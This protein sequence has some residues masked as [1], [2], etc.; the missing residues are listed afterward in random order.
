M[1]DEEAFRETAL[2]RLTSIDHGMAEVNRHLRILNGRV[3]KLE[4]RNAERDIK[5]AREDGYED[6][7]SLAVVTKAQL[8]LVV[9]LMGAMGA[10]AG[11]IARYWPA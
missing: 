3:G 5:E 10:A 6:G 1:T 8:A 9:S 11:L 2:M 4:V 7:K